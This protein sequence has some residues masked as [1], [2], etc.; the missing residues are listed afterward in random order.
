MN[1]TIISPTRVEIDGKDAGI[2][3]DALLAN[4]AERDAFANALAQWHES[5][6]KEDQ[7]REKELQDSIKAADQRAKDAEEA[8]LAKGKAA[9][10]RSDLACQAH[11]QRADEL[12]ADIAEAVSK[13]S[14]NKSE[15]EALKRKKRQELESQLAALQ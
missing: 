7:R 6:V 1:I 12:A 13:F 2:L 11:R 14:R 4:P 8:A 9:D 15:D 3:V 10:E 5:H